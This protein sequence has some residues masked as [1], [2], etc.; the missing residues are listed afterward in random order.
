MVEIRA[1]VFRVFYEVLVDTILEKDCDPSKEK[2][3]RSNIWSIYDKKK[4]YPFAAERATNRKYFQLKFGALDPEYT[5]KGS[6]NHSAL[7]KALRYIGITPPKGVDDDEKD[8]NNA[9]SLLEEFE[10]KYED[11]I[12]KLEEKYSGPLDKNAASFIATELLEKFFENT[13]SQYYDRAWEMLTQNHKD[14][15]WKSFK[16]FEMVHE[17]VEYRTVQVTGATK[18]NDH[19]WVIFIL[20]YRVNNDV[21]EEQIKLQDLMIENLDEFCEIIGRMKEKFAIANIS[22]F[23]QTKII[24]LFDS[25]F[26]HG[27][28][29]E[30][31]IENIKKLE[32]LPSQIQ[33]HKVF[34][35]RLMLDR[36]RWMIDTILSVKYPQI[37]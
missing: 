26:I 35:G 4:K 1:T 29:T 18:K 3:S 33:H 2:P 12:L 16:R 23:N 32:T 19:I 6:V 24:R 25:G 10:N 15:H 11:K 37:Y 31:E 27:L 5:R 21:I 17:S 20:V 7:F 30:D 14:V 22:N 34:A 8:Y 9:K 36:N 28:G 13:K